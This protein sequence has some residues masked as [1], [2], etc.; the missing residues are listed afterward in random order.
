MIIKKVKPNASKAATRSKGG[1]IR[2]L[3]DYIA[4][5]EAGGEDE[6]VLHRGGLGFVADEFSAQQAE[7]MALADEA[8]RSDHPVQHW[9]MSWREGEQPTAQQADAAVRTFLAEMGLEGHQA[10]YAVHADTDNVHLHLAVNR[11]HQETGKVISVNRGFDYDPAHRAIARIEHEQGWQPERGARY[12]V[13]RDGAV[14]RRPS[15]ESP[16]RE[17]STRARDIENHTGEKSAE[18]IAAEDGA[19]AIRRAKDWRDLHAQLAEHGMR[20]E[21]KGSGAI[22]WIGDTAV[23]ASAA[24]RD[25][26]MSALTKRFG[27]YLPPMTTVEPRPIAPEPIAPEAPRWKEYNAARKKHY[28]EKKQDTG[29]RGDMNKDAWKALTKRHREERTKALA[30]DWKGKGEALSAMRSVLAAR[31]AQEKAALKE[32]QQKN[33]HVLRERFPRF[34]SYEEWLRGREQGRELADAWRYRHR[35]VAMIVGGRDGPSQAKPLDIRDF[36]GVADRWRVVYSLSKGGGPAFVDEGKRVRITADD[37]ASVLAALQLSAQKWPKGMTI[38]GPPQFQKLCAELAAEHGFKLNN[39]ELQEQLAAARVKLRS[40]EQ[41]RG[42]PGHQAEQ[43]PG[44]N[45]ESR[46]GPHQRTDKA[47]PRAGPQVEQAL[48]ARPAAVPAVTVPRDAAELYGR[49]FEDI[50]RRPGQADLSR[51]DAAIAV[52]LRMT[53]HAQADVQKAIAA[54]AAKARPGEQRDWNRYAARASAFAF[55]VPGQQMASKLA[56]SKDRIVALERP[57]PPQTREPER[58]RSGPDLKIER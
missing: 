11:V 3:T 48:P 24:G 43:R 12:E 46:P 31:Q 52:R 29:V 35:V 8:V 39:P 15:V 42:T 14:E 32:Q 21:R 55:S 33:R 38:T 28:E 13:A 49:H 50:V 47:P 17:P 7:M 30:G 26:S 19:A 10:L 53:G 37:R 44:T 51:V 57:M 20:F 25:C 9:I 22:I 2:D 41:T 36:T 56:L 58:R 16:M 1:N 54:G 5:P 27:D 6:K 4:G 45:S 40:P 18:R 23:K 34:P